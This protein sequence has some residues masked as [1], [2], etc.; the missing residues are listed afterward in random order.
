MRVRSVIA[1]I[2]TA[3]LCVA[4]LASPVM[5]ADE[6]AVVTDRELVLGLVFGVGEIADELGTTASVVSGED[7]DG[8]LYEE[9]AQVAAADFLAYSGDGAAEA[10][11]LIRSGDPVD[12]LDGL[13]VLGSEIDTFVEARVG[14][15]SGGATIAACGIA[16]VCVAYAAAAVHNT[17][18]LTAVAAVLIGAALW[19]G[20][21]KWCSTS[22]TAASVGAREQFAVEVATQIGS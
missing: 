14:D 12:V 13:E 18:A 8:V 9:Q 1:T 11:D 4:G 15:P 7:A 17:V 6:P 20:A 5:A 3:A 22:S 16:V 10:L 19:C 21:W 2:A